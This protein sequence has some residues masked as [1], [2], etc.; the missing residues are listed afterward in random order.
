MKKWAEFCRVILIMGG[1]KSI[2][3]AFKDSREAVDN[4]ELLGI[5]A[6]GGIS[7]SCQVRSM[8]PGLLKILQDRKVPI[9][10]VYIDQLW[11][12]IFSFSDGK[13]IWKWP[14]SFRR[15]ICVTIGKPIEPHPET[16]VPIQKSLQRLSAEAV[17][18]YVGPF[19]SP[20]VEFVKTCKRQKNVSKVADLIGGGDVKGGMVLTRALILRRLL[21]KFALDSGEKHVGVL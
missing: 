5:F 19:R 11:G 7:P 8:K 6:E 20:V 4:N 21:R 10:P 9:I 16:M 14:R 18:N 13:S 1:P 2:R 15:P 3:K 12:S 17:T